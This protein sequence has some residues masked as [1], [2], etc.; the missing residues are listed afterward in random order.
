L[1]LWAAAVLHGPD[2]EA[3]PKGV[4]ERARL[5]G[6]LHGVAVERERGRQIS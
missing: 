6:H 3:F 2:A 1:T 4:E 5:A